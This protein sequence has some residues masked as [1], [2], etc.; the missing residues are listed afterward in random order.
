MSLRSL[1]NKNG[2]QINPAT[3]ENQ[4]PGEYPCSVHLTR[5]LDFTSL[6]AAVNKGSRIIFL[7]NA[8]GYAVGTK[9]MLYDGINTENDIL[10]VK[11]VNSNAMTLDRPVDTGYNQGATVKRVT[12]AMAATAGSIASPLTYEFRPIAGVWQVCS[13]HIVMASALEPALDRFGGIPALQYG[14]HFKQ[15]NATGRDYTFGVPFRS[16]SSLDLTGADYQKEEKVGTTY[17]THF[18]IDFSALF[19]GMFKLNQLSS[20]QAIVQDDMTA[21]STLEVKLGLRRLS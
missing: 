16:N 18:G 12:Q 8:V 14:I 5:T 7:T 15:A 2:E 9:L 13:M 4:L 19:C 21:L 11:A 17:W 3:Y 20:F 1:Y 6:S 10:T